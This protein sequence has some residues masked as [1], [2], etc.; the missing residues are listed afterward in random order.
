MRLLS[1][2]LVSPLATVLLLAG[3]NWAFAQG[4]IW[5]DYAGSSSVF[6]NFAPATGSNENLHY[7]GVSLSSGA[8]G[9]SL[10]L[11]TGA[12]WTVDTG[13]EGI[14]ITSDYLYTAYGIDANTLSQADH[15]HMTYTSSG[16]TYDGFYTA[17]T[18]GL[19]GA[20]SNGTGTL[21]VTAEVPVLVATSM[22]DSMGTQTHFCPSVTSCTPNGASL[23]QF[24][25]G[26][27]RPQGTQNEN[28][29]LNLTSISSGDLS[30]MAPGYMVTKQGIQLGL[31]SA[32][33][34]NTSFS[35]LLPSANSVPTSLG[36]DYARAA[37]A[38]EWQTPAATI[39]IS[40]AKNASANGTYYGTLLVDTGIANMELSSGGSY[41][42]PTYDAANPSQS[43]S[44]S[45]YLPG[46]ASAASGQPVSYT[47]VYQGTC[48]GS[49]NSCPPYNPGSYGLSPVY[50][51]NSFDAPGNGIAF[52][53]T[54]A[55][56][57]AYPYINT[58][59][60][61]LNYFNIVYDPVGGFFGYQV[62][63]DPI[64]TSNDPTLSESIAL[65][66]STTI[67]DGTTVS[68]PTLLFSQFTDG[69]DGTYG[70][71]TVAQLSTPGTVTMAG[72][73]SSA[74][75]CG[76]G[77][78][79]CAATALELTG[80]RFIF[81][82]DNK[83]LG[84]TAVDSGATLA[85]AGK[86]S[87]ASSAG[88][89]VN[90]TFDI[91]GTSAG[92]TVNTLTGVGHVNLGAQALTIN[93]ATSN[94]GGT[95]SDGGISGGAGGALAITGGSQT[96]SGM[97]LYGCHHHH[98]GCRPVTRRQGQHRDLFWCYG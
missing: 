81:T 62:A 66:G 27:G 36:S 94:F 45:V 4:T 92:A 3:G 28:P 48:A 13:S 71:Q 38:T 47:L 18:V 88:L 23:E 41:W 14:V 30:S 90:G 91:S 22:Q 75:I 83:Y 17:L 65:Q 73:I 9:S 20:G 19:Y 32:E 50:P 8:A 43:S 79:N 63:D 93:N 59:T 39:T 56:S 96:L 74:I 86:G 53:T 85:L 97:N 12:E 55:S 21:V 72:V 34:R 67:P 40:K 25:V 57:T 15:G 1:S 80:G 77:G 58:G 61:F 52:V 70:A 7:L 26:F 68:V 87:I 6:L 46:A 84:A 95:I 11:G 33:A 37:T 31:T 5:N 2:R 16:L 60:E 89:V 44:I 24:G 29:L 49:D 98:S 76:S 69:Y 64:E 35:G 42:N 51:K 78:V 54:T 10:S 82:A